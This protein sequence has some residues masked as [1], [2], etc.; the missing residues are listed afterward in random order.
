MWAA[1]HYV[2]RN[3]V[4]AGLVSKAE[5]YG[6]SSV[7]GHCNLKEDK[8]LTR[9]SKWM[10]VFDQIDNWSEWL[11]VG[12]DR[13]KIRVVRRNIEKRLPCGSEEFINRVERIVSRVVHY[14]PQGEAKAADYRLLKSCASRSIPFIIL[15]VSLCCKQMEEIM[16][17]ELGIGYPNF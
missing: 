6:W 1:V 4:R 8:I 5:D 9:R 11:A 3:P 17:D 15:T 13:Q 12:D 14:R 2:E 7:A 10:E 16:T